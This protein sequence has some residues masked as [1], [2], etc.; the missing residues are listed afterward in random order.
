MFDVTYFIVGLLQKLIFIIPIA[1]V[2]VFIIALV[3][4]NVKKKTLSSSSEQKD[5]DKLKRLKLFV[6]ISGVIAAVFV[7]ILVV[8][9]G[10][11]FMFMNNM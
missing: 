5:I 3:I 2:L 6:K 10:L 1:S 7:F 9:V 8:L 4:Y 11:F